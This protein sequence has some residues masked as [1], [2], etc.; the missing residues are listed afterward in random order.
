MIS[1]KN[2]T[3]RIKDFELAVLVFLLIFFSNDTYMF[4]SNKTEFMVS[5]S[6]YIMLI[7]CCINVF[8]FIKSNYIKKQKIWY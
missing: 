1:T 2:Y 4:G 3:I 5:L 6:R 8:G 7:F